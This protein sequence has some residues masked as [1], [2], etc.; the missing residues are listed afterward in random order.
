MFYEPAEGARPREEVWST[1]R[2]LRHVPE[3]IA[4]VR[5][6]Y[7]PDLHLLHDVHHRLTPIEAAQL[8]KA[9]EPVPAVLARGPRPGRAPG[10]PPARAPA[11]HHAAGDRRGVQPIWDCQQLITEQLIDFIRMSVVHPGGITHLRRILHLAELYRVRS[12]CHG[13][14]DLSPVCMAAA[15]H[16]DLAIPNFGLQEYMRHTRRDRRVFP[17]AYTFRDGDA[18]SR[19]RARAGGDD[20]RGAGGVVPVPAGAAA[21]ARAWRTGRCTTGSDPLVTCTDRNAPSASG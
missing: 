7:G 8:G 20:R 3:V 21:D 5:A 19:R 9:L 13:A 11:H 2:Y 14:T 4:R 1:R 16:L 12:G 15:L 6:A 18:A 10:Q 17:H